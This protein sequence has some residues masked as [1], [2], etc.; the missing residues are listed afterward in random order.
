MNTDLKFPEDFENKIICG[1]NLEV[2]PQMPDESVDLVVT[3]PPY[4]GVIR[5]WEELW[6]PQNFHKAHEYLW[7]VWNEALRIL[8]PG[9]KL[10]INMANTKRRPYLTNVAKIYEW[11]VGKCEPLGEIIWH[12][13]YGQIGTAWGSYCNPSDPALADQHEYIIVLRK[14]G[15]R[16]KRSGYYLTPF[17]FKSWRNSVWSIAPEK[18][19]AIGHVAP[20]PIQ[21]PA[22]IIKLYSYPDEIVLDPFVGSGTTPVASIKT[23]RRYIGIDISEEYCDISKERIKIELTQPELPLGGG[24]HG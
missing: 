15:K 3:S 21:I 16:E 11:S 14:Y 5:F 23:G 24:S 4:P 2:M 8:K 13:G 10:I 17:E 18:A 6:H 19:S 12:K 9:C 7:Q 22:R 20:F 1:D